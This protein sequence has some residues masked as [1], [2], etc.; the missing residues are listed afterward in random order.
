MKDA[1]DGWDGL[2]LSLSLSLSLFLSG[3]STHRGETSLSV[4]CVCVGC[5][6]MRCCCWT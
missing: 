1:G 2:A 6:C 5:C 3:N 4:D